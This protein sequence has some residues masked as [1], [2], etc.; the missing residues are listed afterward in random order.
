MTGQFPDDERTPSPPHRLK[1][2]HDSHEFI[3]ESGTVV[4]KHVMYKR[5][6][7]KYRISLRVE[8]CDMLATESLT[9]SEMSCGPVL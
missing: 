3:L 5:I 7:M 9:F 1:I 4:N 8:I 2:N 6:S